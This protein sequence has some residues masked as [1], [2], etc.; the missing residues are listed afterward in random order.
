MILK[1][2]N[3]QVYGQSSALPHVLPNTLGLPARAEQVIAITD[4][5]TL[6]ACST[7]L[8][9]S[10]RVILGSGS[11]VVIH[12]P[13]AAAA[14]LN[15][16]KGKSITA[17][18]VL[19]AASGEDWH[20]LV[21]W[22][23][24]QGFAGLENLALIPGTMGAAPVQNIG[25]YGVELRDRLISV[26]AWDFKTES[27]K[28]FSNDDC[29]FGY[30]DSIFKNAEIQGPWNAPRYFIT[31]VQLQLQPMHMAKL[32]IDYA[33][34]RLALAGK[35]QGQDQQQNEK[36]ISAADIAHAVISIRQQKLPNP[37][38]LGN[39]G[40]F[41]KNP[42]V[43]SLQAKNLQLLHPDLPKYPAAPGQFVAASDHS[44]TAQFSNTHCKLSAAWMID[45]C[46]FKGARRGDVGVHAQHALVLVN[47]GAG[48]GREILM[49]AQEI[50][51]AVVA[52]FGVFL[53]PEPVFMP[54]GQ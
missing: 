3:V 14:L 46:G 48:T 18:G 33:D 45:R 31:Q 30:R 32:K 8:K 47:Y 9:N 38:E 40:S 24:Q 1:A 5:E 20:Q 11:N 10:P 25:A 43:S 53:E 2:V 23:L 15:Q 7:A 17:D 41:F 52:K 26:T 27:L 19:T 44:K 29:Q 22:S 50:Q 4:I 21:M 42:I 35:F 39:V 13:I 49:L 6:A 12:A 34:L 28:T 36:P 37:Q 54:A 51:Q 16:L